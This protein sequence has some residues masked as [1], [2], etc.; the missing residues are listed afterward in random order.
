MYQYI[1]LEVSKDF[2]FW[3]EIIYKVQI[4]GLTIC[5]KITLNKK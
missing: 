3:N 1:N 2:L 4:K 5:I